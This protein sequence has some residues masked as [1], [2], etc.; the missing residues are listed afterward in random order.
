[1]C[2]SRRIVC[3]S[4]NILRVRLGRVTFAAR[5]IIVLDI[6]AV[7]HVWR[8]QRIQK[9]VASVHALF[10]N[11]ES[12]HTSQWRGYFATFT[13]ASQ[14]HSSTPRAQSVCSEAINTDIPRLGRDKNL[15]VYYEGPTRRLHC[16]SVQNSRSVACVRAS[17]QERALSA[18][19]GRAS[20]SC[21]SGAGSVSA[22]ALPL[23]SPFSVMAPSGWSGSERQ[24]I[25]I[26]HVLFN[27]T[28]ISSLCTCDFF[29]LE[30]Y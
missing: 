22:D 17:L 14:R 5:C 15:R 18:A 7:L 28:L 12:E 21:S 6:P 11:H 27:M 20:P 1:M 8:G 23:A 3:V 2:I 16:R 24:F 10:V 9:P 26:K 4:T 19:Q 13:T 25:S 29:V 30:I